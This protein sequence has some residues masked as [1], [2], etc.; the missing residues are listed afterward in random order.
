MSTVAKANYTTIEVAG[1]EVRLSNPDKLFFPKPKFTKLDLAEYYVSIQ[2]AAA[3]RDQQVVEGGAPRRFRRLQPERA[4]PDDRLGLLGAAGAG[5]A[6][7]LPARVGRG[8]RRRS[9][10]STARHGSRAGPQEGR[11]CGRHRRARR[12]ARRPSGP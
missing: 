5:C 12:L 9:P 3:E 2:A 11:P 10:R 1:R 6:G 4:R 7:L 8:P